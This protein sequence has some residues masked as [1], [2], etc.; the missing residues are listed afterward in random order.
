MSTA[1]FPSRSPQRPVNVP[2]GPLAGI[3]FSACL[4]AQFSFEF[5]WHCLFPDV[6][7]ESKGSESEER[8]DR[9]TIHPPFQPSQPVFVVI[10]ALGA[11]IDYC[12]YGL[13][14]AD[15]DKNG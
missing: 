3:S 2:V 11:F 1:R 14:L 5:R 12:E 6:K 4:A 10:D 15:F 9:K 7:I 8:R 13:N